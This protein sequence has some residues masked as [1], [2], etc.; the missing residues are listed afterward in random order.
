MAAS[1]TLGKT[2]AKLISSLY[3]QNKLIFTIKD[4]STI[5]GLDYFSA[6]RFISELKK[7]KIISTLKKVK[8][9][10]IPQELETIDNLLGIG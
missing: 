7:R 2:S 4:V 5:T 3:D 1:R 8:N 10:I 6:G 9:I